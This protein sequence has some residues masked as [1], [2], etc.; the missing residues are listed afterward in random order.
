MVNP[1]EIND[2][3]VLIHAISVRSCASAVLSMARS[4]LLG[5]MLVFPSTT[6]KLFYHEIISLEKLEFYFL[7]SSKPFYQ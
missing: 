2:T 6:L 5:V 1:N 3:A 4:V 7:P